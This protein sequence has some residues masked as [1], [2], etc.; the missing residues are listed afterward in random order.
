VTPQFGFSEILVLAL[1]AI[2]VVG[3]KDLPVLMRNIGNFF[4]SLQSL[5][6]EFKSAFAEMDAS[7]EISEI[8]KEI[9]N[10]KDI[11]NYE[12]FL[13]SDIKGELLSL[14][15]ELREEISPNVKKKDDSVP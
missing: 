5:G 14:E 4:S 8:Q 12:N 9:S 2:I 13:D 6:N 7:N 11:G 3:P 1:L 15:T 10:L